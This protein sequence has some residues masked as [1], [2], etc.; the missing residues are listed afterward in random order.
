MDLSP[1]ARRL[2]QYEAD[3]SNARRPEAAGPRSRIQRRPGRRRLR[4]IQAPDAGFRP[5]RVR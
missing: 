3:A 2:S 1:L 5:F 4:G